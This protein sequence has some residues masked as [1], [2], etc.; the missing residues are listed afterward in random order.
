MRRRFFINSNDDT[1]Y[2]TLEALSDGAFSF[3]VEDT[4]VYYRL[5]RQGVFHKFI[6][7]ESQKPIKRGQIIELKGEN[8][9]GSVGRFLTDVSFNLSGNSL[10]LIFGDDYK[11]KYD[12]SNYPNVFV[13]LFQNVNIVN[14]SSDFLPATILSKGCYRGMFY[15]CTRLVNAP[16]L[17][18]QDLVYSCYNS[19]FY[20]CTNLNYIKMLATDI[21][22]SY[23]LMDWVNGV[24]S[25]GTFVKHP[26]MTSLPTGVSGIPEGWTVVNDGEESGGGNDF[27]IEFPLYI[28]ADY[29]YEDEPGYVDC[30]SKSLEEAFYVNLRNFMIHT[31]KT[32]GES[33]DGFYYVDLSLLDIHIF[34]DVNGEW[35]EIED[36]YADND[37]T[38][39][40]CSHKLGGYYNNYVSIGNGFISW[41]Y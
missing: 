40:D 6:T 8:C 21:S 25:T 37:F 13:F 16:E 14:V 9:T 18:S 5:D 12:I 2:C 11:N 7:G 32:H 23:C 36:I 24:S 22:A 20:G 39:I 4:D 19:M 30:Y 35:S 41:G 31:C 15:G 38:Y 27:G 3:E 29:C 17:P 34:V 10:S 26:D 1:T 33:D 28:E